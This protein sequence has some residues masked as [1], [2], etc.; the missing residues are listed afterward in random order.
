MDETGIIPGNGW[1]RM[2]IDFLSTTSIKET[3]RETSSGPLSN[4][5]STSGR[6]TLTKE[7]NEALSLKSYLSLS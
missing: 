1:V 5:D 3:E 2:V 6:F 7:I 4:D